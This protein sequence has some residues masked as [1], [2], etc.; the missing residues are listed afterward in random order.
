LLVCAARRRRF[1]DV[2]ANQSQRILKPEKNGLIVELLY[3]T[4]DRSD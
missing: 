1:Q 2:R 3:L 4:V